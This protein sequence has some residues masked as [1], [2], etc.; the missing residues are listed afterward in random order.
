MGQTL[1]RGLILLE[2]LALFYILKA[3]LIDMDWSP[4]VG[5]TLTLASF[6]REHNLLLDHE[7]LIGSFLARL[8]Q[9]GILA[10]VA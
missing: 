7:G 4:M 10:L 9:H 5:D 6:M 8:M 3:L 1:P 2:R